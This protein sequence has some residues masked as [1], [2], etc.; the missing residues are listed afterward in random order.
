MPRKKPEELKSAPVAPA[1]EATPAPAP[2][3]ATAPEI[4]LWNFVIILLPK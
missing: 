2:A 4:Y 3:P 1:P